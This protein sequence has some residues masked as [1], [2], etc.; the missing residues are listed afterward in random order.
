MPLQTERTAKVDRSSSSIQQLDKPEFETNIGLVFVDDQ[1]QLFAD[2]SI[3]GA[4]PVSEIGIDISVR[5]KPLSENIWSGR[6]LR[7]FVSGTRPDPKDVFERVFRIPCHWH[8]L[9]IQH[10]V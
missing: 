6:G 9:N 10:V 2:V 5:E 3:A 4:L 1:G 7:E 8:S